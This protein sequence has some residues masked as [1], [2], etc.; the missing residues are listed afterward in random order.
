MST[1]IPKARI[2]RIIKQS[3]GTFK[4]SKEEIVAKIQEH[5]QI[6]GEISVTTNAWLYWMLGFSEEQA[7]DAAKKTLQENI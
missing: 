7:K 4:R 2:N 6:Y 1:K 3:G 5:A